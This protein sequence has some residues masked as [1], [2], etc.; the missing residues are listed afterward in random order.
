MAIPFRYGCL[1][2]FVFDYEELSI[3]LFQFVLR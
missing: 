3:I 1:T 2:Y